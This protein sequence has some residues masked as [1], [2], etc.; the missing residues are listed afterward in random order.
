MIRVGLN[1]FTNAHHIGLGSAIWYWHFVDVVWFFDY[2]KVSVYPKVYSF[3]VRWLFS[4]NHKDIGTLY[5][6]F[7]GFSGVTGTIISLY[8][9]ATLGYPASNFLNSNHHLYNVIVTGHAF[10]MIFFL[11]TS[12]LI[13]GLIWQSVC[14]SYDRSEHPKIEIWRIR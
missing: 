8:I 7:A 1:H 10:I 5:L 13:G 4:T 11:V 12:A 14:T 9:R 6:L 2:L 3:I